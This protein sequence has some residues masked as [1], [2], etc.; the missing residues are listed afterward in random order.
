MTIFGFAVQFRRV[1][2]SAGNLAQFPPPW[3]SSMEHTSLEVHCCVGRYAGQ[4]VGRQRRGGV[5]RDFVPT[6]RINLRV[7]RAVRLLGTSEIRSNCGKQQACHDREK[8][9]RRLTYLDL[10]QTHGTLLSW[11]VGEKLELVK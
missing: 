1:T 8:H 7:N 11:G 2:P 6:A 3:G 9:S 4:R 10:E 5:G